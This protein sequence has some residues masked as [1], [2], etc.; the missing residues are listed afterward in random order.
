M[1]DVH[2]IRCGPLYFFTTRLPRGGAS[3]FMDEKDDLIVFD[4]EDYF[5]L[6][7][8]THASALE[9]KQTLASAWEKLRH[10]GVELPEEMPEM[11]VDGRPRDMVSGANERMR[12][13]LHAFGCVP[14]DSA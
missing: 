4:G 5:V 14:R 10:A 7:I 12:F 2:I 8:D 9:I 13:G 3:L 6:E 11:I 1:D